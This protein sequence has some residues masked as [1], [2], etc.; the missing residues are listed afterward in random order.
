MALTPEDARAAVSEV[1]SEPRY[2]SAAVLLQAE[3]AAQP[4][5]SHAV[6]LLE[7][8]SDRRRV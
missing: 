2:R 7:R 6:A 4:P 8:L 5:P 3:I 1:L